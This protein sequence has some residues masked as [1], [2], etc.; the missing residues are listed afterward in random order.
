ME[1]NFLDNND[2]DKSELEIINKIRDELKKE[3]ELNIDDYDERDIEKMLND[4]WQVIR[5]LNYKNND[6][7][8]TIEG[9]KKTLQWRKCFCINDYRGEQFPEEFYKVGG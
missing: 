9:I 7:G 5:Y 1:F 4:D 2:N 3:F 6:V 8:Q